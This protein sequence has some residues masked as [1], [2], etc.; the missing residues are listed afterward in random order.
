MCINIYIYMYSIYIIYIGSSGVWTH[1]LTLV[2]QETHPNPFSALVIF[3]VGSCE[4]AH[5]QLQSTIFLPMTSSI[6]GTKDHVNWLRWSVAYFCRCWSQILIPWII[7]WVA[8]IIDISH[9]AQCIFYNDVPF[10]FLILII[11]VMSPFF[12]Q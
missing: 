3:Q 8:G 9:H 11:Y 5:G 12:F 10:L 6:A 4:F 1:G 2:T 7:S